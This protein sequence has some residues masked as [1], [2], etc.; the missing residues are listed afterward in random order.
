MIWFE[1]RV[2]R[3]L[4]QEVVRKYAIFFIKGLTVDLHDLDARVITDRE[5]LLI[6]IEQLLSN[7][8]KYTSMAGLRSISKTRAPLYC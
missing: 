7:S 6:I 3:G 5:W 2:A 8:L 4:S 1:A